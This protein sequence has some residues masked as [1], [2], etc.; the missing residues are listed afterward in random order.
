M[1]PSALEISRINCSWK[2]ALP[3][4]INDLQPLQDLQQEKLMM[5]ETSNIT[6]NK[7]LINVIDRSFLSRSFSVLKNDLMLNLYRKSEII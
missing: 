3:G 1:N 2:T 4:G 5:K 7:L 6:E